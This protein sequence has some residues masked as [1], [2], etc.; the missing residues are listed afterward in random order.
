MSAV[1]DNTLAQ[2][3]ASMRQ[4]LTSSASYNTLDPKASAPLAQQQPQ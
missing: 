1:K 3:Y 4:Q 2:N